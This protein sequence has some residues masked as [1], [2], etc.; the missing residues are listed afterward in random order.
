[1]LVNEV[2]VTMLAAIVL[3]LLFLYFWLRRSQKK[4][5]LERQ[6]KLRC[7]ELILDNRLKLANSGV[8]FDRLVDLVKQKILPEQ[9]EAVIGMLT[10][11]P[12]SYNIDD[13]DDPESL[14]IDL[15]FE[16]EPASSKKTAT[17]LGEDEE[18]Q[19]EV[20]EKM[21]EEKEKKWMRV[22]HNSF[23]RA[24]R[25]KEITERQAKLRLLVKMIELGKKA[26][27]GD[28]EKSVTRKGYELTLWD[29]FYEDEYLD[30]QSE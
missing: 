15:D 20:F 12:V 7:K 4:N 8:N 16:S 19:P 13:S 30:L 28:S 11:Q 26:V 2:E 9:L 29:R 27:E 21:G 1:M 22:A 23:R 6:R 25:E 3:F 17:D 24:V 18:K 10:A 5:K 14:E